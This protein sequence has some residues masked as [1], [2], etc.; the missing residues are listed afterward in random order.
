MTD[1]LKESLNYLLASTII[2]IIF[3]PIMIGILYKFNQVSGLKKTKLG[4]RKGTNSIFMRIMKSNETNGTPNMGGILIWIIVPLMTYI[5]APLT[6][7]LQVLLVGFMLFGL[8]GFIDVAIF[9][10]GFKNNPKIKAMQETFEW[11]LGKLTV[12]VLLNIGIMLLLYNTGEFQSVNLLN[13]LAISISPALLVLIAIVG[14]FAIYSGELTDGL[15]GLM[16]GI[17]TIITCSLS[18][19]LIVQGQYEFLPFLGI[20]L[21][22]EIVD[23][24]FNIPPAR[25]WNGGPGAMP[26]SFALFFIGLVTDNLIPYFLMS[27]ITWLI[28][29]SSAL[30]MFSMKFFKRRIFKIAPIHHHFQ[31]VGWPQYKI[32]MRFW[33]FTLFVCILGIYV[34]LL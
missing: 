32:T 15:D 26:I 27:S 34:A 14:Q 29:L 9:T 6:P 31:A 25:F 17:F 13:I 1:I 24:Y 10:N 3:A 20:L 22:V 18:V 12:A 7:Q 33:L 28:M 2:S 11:R 8:W 23:L 21:G 19:L 16:I 5:F 30:Q 4:S